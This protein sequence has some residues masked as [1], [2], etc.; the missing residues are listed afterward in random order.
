MHLGVGNP[1]MNKLWALSWG[2]TVWGG[3]VGGELV[4]HFLY[5]LMNK[6]FR[7]LAFKAKHGRMSQE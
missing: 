7:F 5:L 2:L 6:V 1:E 3:W 4:R